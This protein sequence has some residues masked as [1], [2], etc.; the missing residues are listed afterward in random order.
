LHLFH[1]L[2]KP[3]H[4][5]KFFGLSLGSFRL[6]VFK[7]VDTPNSDEDFDTNKYQVVQVQVIH[8]HGDRAPINWYPAEFHG[9]WKCDSKL[10]HESPVSRAKSSR[11]YSSP[12][13]TSEGKKYYP[14]YP[15]QLTPLG[16]N[17]MTEL[18][19]KLR[20][21]YVEKLH[22]LNKELNPD[23]VLAR[24]TPIPRTEE[25]L[26]SVFAG[27]YPNNEPPS[28]VTHI[29]INEPMWYETSNCQRLKDLFQQFH[30]SNEYKEYMKKELPMVRDQFNNYL[31]I[32]DKDGLVPNQ[33]DWIIQIY[34][35]FKCFQSLNEDRSLPANVPKET[36]DKME[37]ICVVDWF[38]AFKSKEISRLGMGRFL[39][40]IAT[41]IDEKISAK[42]NLKL[43]VYSGHDTT[44]GPLLVAL[45]V[46]DD[47]WPPIGSNIIL[48]VLQEIKKPQ[49]YFVHMKYN[50]K[51]LKI[52]SCESTI[53]PLKQFKELA[54]KIIPKDFEVECK[55]KGDKI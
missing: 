5:Y 10:L 21:K 12:E 14:C 23:E 37:G 48:E 9:Q 20:E 34:D 39:K 13:T 25:S 35:F 28:I 27:L 30:A 8:R 46:F 26:Q 47:K 6:N 4:L 55:S 18:G 36:F 11:D 54:S 41:H 42:N 31:S 38:A 1:S 52:P 45:D 16:K 29:P 19:K 15:G 24:S 2:L 32:K 53:C 17:Q 22:L 33:K 51:T 49:E 3:N 43:I 44:V 7:K 40:E 50:D